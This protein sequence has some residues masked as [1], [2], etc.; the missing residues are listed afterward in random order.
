MWLSPE[1][2]KRL[3]PLKA[4]I[5]KKFDKGNW[6]EVAALTGCLPEINGHQRL[7]RSLLWGDPDYPSQ[8]MDVLTTIASRDAGN[9]KIIEDYVSGRFPAA[10]GENVSSMRAERRIYFTP[11]VFE[12]PA[13]LLVDRSLVSVM[14]PFSAA[15]TSV[16]DA[17]KAAAGLQALVCQRADD[18][19]QHSVVM[20]EVFALIL[21][22]HIVVCD[23]TDKN[24][25]VFYECGIAHTLGKHVVPI[26]QHQT[27]IPFDLRHH[28]FLIYHPNAEGLTKLTQSLSERLG[29]LKPQGGGFST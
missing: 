28:R 17:I 19:W 20:Q 15:F 25:N 7:L 29:T 4:V 6:L 10:G 18:I 9:I 16:F 24:A 11:G 8:V 2:Q 22:S 1:D 12:V 13:D 14:M 3:L 21:R 5:E 26:A 23:F 27:D